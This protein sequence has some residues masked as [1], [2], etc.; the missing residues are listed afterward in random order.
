M[1]SISWHPDRRESIH[2]TSLNQRDSKISHEIK[3]NGQPG[4]RWLPNPKLI[5]QYLER[6]DTNSMRNP[7]VERND[8]E[9]INSERLNLPTI[10]V[11]RIKA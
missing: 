11:G 10:H 9:R 5:A 1:R 2:G 8:E 3:A 4:A 6:S 7:N